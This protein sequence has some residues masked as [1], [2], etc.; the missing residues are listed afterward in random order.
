MA[1]RIPWDKYEAAILLD[2][3]QSVINNKISRSEAVTTVSNKLRVMSINRGLVIDSVF[4][5]ENGIA[6]QMNIMISLLTDTT[7]GLHGAS[8]LFVSIVDIYKKNPSEFIK[9]LDEAKKGGTNMTSIKNQFHNWL[10]SSVRPAEVSYIKKLCD[11]IDSY[12]QTSKAIGYSM[13][14]IN[15]P[16]DVQR[17]ITTIEK[18]VFFRAKN[19][20]QMHKIKKAMEVFYRFIQT[21]HFS[22]EEITENEPMEPIVEQ[23]NEYTVDFSHK[24]DMTYTRPLRLIFKNQVHTGFSNWNQLYVKILSRLFELHNDTIVSLCGQNIS[25]DGRIEIATASQKDVMIAPK[26]FA[27]DMFVETNISAL[28]ITKKISCLLN[29]CGIDAQEVQIVYEKKKSALSKDNTNGATTKRNSYPPSKDTFYDYL[30]N[31]VKVAPSTGRSYASQINTCEVYATKHSIGTGKLYGANDNDEACQTAIQLI[32]DVKFLEFS[33]NAHNAPMAA[34]RKYYEYLSGSSVTTTRMPSAFKEDFSGV[35]FSRYKEL[36]SK[37][38]QKGFR[39]NDKLSIRRFRMQWQRIFDEEIQYDDDTICKHIAYITVQHGN[40]AYL[41]DVMLDDNT[42][43]RLLAYINTLFTQ[44]KLAIYYDALYNEFS[45]DFASGRINNVEML[46]TYLDY[47]NDG[48]MHLRRSY[49]AADSDVEVDSTEEVRSFLISQG[50]A[51]QTVDIISSLS[52]IARD[53]IIWALAGPNSSEFVRNKK[54]EYF[55]ADIVELTQREMDLITELISLAIAD[56]EYIGGKELTDTIQ[57]KLPSI[58]ERYPFLTWLGL[59]DVIAFK[60]RDN[61]SFKGKI[62]SA[63]G[64]DLSMKDVFANFAKTHDHFTLAQLNMLKNDFD[65]PIYFDSVYANSLR[66]NKNEF[67]SQEQAQ[68]NI[69]G[70]DSAIDRFCSG[71][72]ISLKDISLFGGFP[73]AYFQWNHFLLQHYVANYS[74]KYKLIHAGFNAG[75]PVGAIVKRSSQMDTF[76]EVLI[77]ALAES[78]IR[79]NSNDALQYL[80]DAGYL[81]RRSFGNLNALLVKANLYRMINKGE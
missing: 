25:G 47:I 10:N 29:I 49:I 33:R 68:F 26:Q 71:E 38:Y 50:T 61:F 30:V 80:C 2:A 32:D 56:K 28:D 76:D 65:T 40:M 37:D 75:N 3:S 52:H 59:R 46:K 17:I 63:Y 66:I 77:R 27:E 45:D 70:T 9:I 72:F 11:V 44:G 53:K 39:L 18:D 57:N 16:Y 14:K 21:G 79:L 19:G 42:K 62:I 74:K 12:S 23:A 22:A 58:L 15:D 67:V 60:F 31:T 8:K 35:N 78:N 20:R 41:P 55:H 5:N 64:E 13:Y 36:L 6:M 81:A 73:D 24:A 69:D 7:T 51:V 4:R 54:G 34:L 48:R 43:F 1:I